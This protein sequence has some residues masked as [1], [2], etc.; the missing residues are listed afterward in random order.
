VNFCRTIVSDILCGAPIP[1]TFRL[2]CSGG[3]I[4]SKPYFTGAAYRKCKRY[5]VTARSGMPPWAARHTYRHPPVVARTLWACA[6]MQG[7]AAPGTRRACP[8]RLLG[9]QEAPARGRGGEMSGRRN[10]ARLPGR[11]ASHGPGDCAPSSTPARTTASGAPLTR[12]SHR[13]G[14][15]PPH[16]TSAAA[17]GTAHRPPGAAFPSGRGPSSRGNAGPKSQGA[18]V[19]QDHGCYNAASYPLDQ[20]KARSLQACR[21]ACCHGK[22]PRV[23]EACQNGSLLV[24]CPDESSLCCCPSHGDRQ[25]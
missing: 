22:Q 25:K 14:A 9:A 11:G 8:G 13:V 20:S 1:W 2:P 18:K 23:L 3:G 19:A 24:N 21:L 15:A 17:R 16:G 10:S 6:R 12:R 5:F 7:W 4:F